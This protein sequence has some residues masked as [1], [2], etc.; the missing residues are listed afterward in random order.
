[1]RIGPTGRNLKGKL[2]EGNCGELTMAV[3]HQD[4]AVI[5]EFGTQVAWI[6]LPP[7]I[8]RQLAQALIEHATRAESA[9][10]HGC[11]LFPAGT[12]RNRG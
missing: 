6:G 7:Q 10:R 5:L 2:C 12:P 4:G 8:A 9:Q 1:M 11:M 3:A